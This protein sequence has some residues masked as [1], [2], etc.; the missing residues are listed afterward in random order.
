MT[1]PL[2]AHPARYIH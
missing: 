1:L 2:A